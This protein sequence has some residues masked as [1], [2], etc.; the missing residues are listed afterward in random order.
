MIISALH[1]FIFVAI[2]KTGTHAVRRALRGHLG[3]GDQEQ[4]GLF[5]RSRLDIPKLAQIGHGHLS[6]QDVR[7]FL[8][9][10]TFD[11]ALKFAFVRNPFDRFVSYCAFMTRDEGQFLRNPQAVMHHFLFVEP[12]V[13]HILFRP[14][15]DFVTDADG[16]LLTDTIGRF[17][18]IQQSYDEITGK[19]GIP[20]TVLEKVNSSQR[21][22]YRDYYN[23]QA[24][25]GV[26]ARYA[27]D[28]DLF[29]YQF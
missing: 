24:I 3:D 10:D 29:G 4:V 15:S 2:P 11:Q 12:P 8:D 13:Q 18:T 17:E 5:V 16:R 28:L 19:I 6:L 20:S 7:P 9:P 22:E 26:A 23:Q 1:Q 25:D 21:S 27:R 14:Q